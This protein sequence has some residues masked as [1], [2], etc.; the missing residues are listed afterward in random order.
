[1]K[2]P[3]QT[4]LKGKVVVVACVVVC[5]LETPMVNAARRG[6]EDKGNNP[7]LQRLFTNTGRMWRRLSRLAYLSAHRELWLSS[8][9]LPGLV[10]KHVSLI[11][12]RQK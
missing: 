10:V 12:S 3:T 6:D 8:E 9:R 4:L 11:T 7:S 2:W 5:G 1:M